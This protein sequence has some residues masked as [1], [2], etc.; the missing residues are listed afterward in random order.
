LAPQAILALDWSISKIYFSETAWL[1]WAEI[2]W[3]A[4]MEGSVLSFLK[5]EWKVSDTGSAQCWASY[6]VS[7]HLAER[8]QIRRFLE[9]DQSETRIACGELG[10]KHLWKVLY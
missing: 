9:I 8:F 3:E 6:H 5:A 4:P 2:R 7:H 1:K 10:E